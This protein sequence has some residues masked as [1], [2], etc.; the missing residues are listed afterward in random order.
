MK[1][2]DSIPKKV[3]TH[4]NVYKHAPQFLQ[5]YHLSTAAFHLANAQPNH[6]CDAN[7]KPPVDLVPDSHS[8]MLSATPKQKIKMNAFEVP[9]GI[10]LFDRNRPLH[11]FELI[12]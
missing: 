1:K 12:F 3:L 6:Y 2:Y 9:A 10:Y 8:V 5:L 7:G 11:I 4:Y